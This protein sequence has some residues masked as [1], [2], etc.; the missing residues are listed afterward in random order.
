MDNVQA[1]LQ[2][3][4]FEKAVQLASQEL[5]KSPT[6]STL[7]LARSKA[8]L[9]LKLPKKA[10]EDAEAAV[11]AAGPRERPDTQ[12]R[13]AISLYAEG[14]KLRAKS[15]VR[16]FP[17]GSKEAEL[18]TAK[19]ALVPGELELPEAE[20]PVHR[21][22]SL[23]AIQPRKDW[24]QS[25]ASITLT[26][27]AKDVAS[28]AE[29]EIRPRELKLKSREFNWGITLSRAIDPSQSSYKITPLKIEFRLQKSESGSW[30]ALEVSSQP[31]PKSSP[32]LSFEKSWD[33]L[34]D[35]SDSDNADDDPNAFF[36]RIYDEATPDVKRAMMKSY[37]ESNGTTLSTN[38]DEVKRGK[39]ET[40][41]PS[42]MEA[43]RW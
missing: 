6:S 37:V 23:A 41:P 15:L 26:V 13:R 34:E 36:R 16:F 2:T 1:C 8:Y 25:S 30:P 39:V 17:K 42:G 24:Y 32:K 7:L 18:W 31:A 22:T 29:V 3:G 27:Y 43:R 35:G 4:D 10:L 38:W 11:V 40:Q 9:R 20:I 12:L 14:E 28:S 21:N 5:R 19:L 33:D